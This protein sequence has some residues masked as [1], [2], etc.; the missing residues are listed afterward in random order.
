MKDALGVLAAA[1]IALAA[2][3]GGAALALLA[4]LWA[5]D[6]ATPAAPK[7]RDLPAG[8]RIVRAVQS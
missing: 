4:V 5:A 3:A 7:Q 6:H 8:D 1:L 2:L